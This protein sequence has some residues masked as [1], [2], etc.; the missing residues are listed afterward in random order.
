METTYEKIE[1][2]IADY[3]IEGHQIV[4]RFRIPGSDDTVESKA[5]IRRIDSTKSK[6]IKT[7]KSSAI[8]EARGF[9]FRLMRQVL[10]TG[11]VGRIGHSAVSSAMSASTS[12][13]SGWTSEEKEAAI[14]AAFEN[15][16][17]EFAFDPES[18][19]WKRA[20]EPS[21]FKAHLLRHPITDKY[22]RDLLTR[23]MVQM[24][25]ADGDLSAAEKEALQNQMGIS[26]MEIDELE[27]VAHP[28]LVVEFEK[29]SA[30]SKATMY[31]LLY[32]IALTDAQLTATE[33]EQ[34]DRFARMMELEGEQ[35]QHLQTMARENILTQAIRAGR[36]LDE[37]R[38]L[39]EQIDA[40]REEVD[41]TWV[42]D[43]RRNI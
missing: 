42:S 32:A 8:R 1:P 5:P 41:R 36:S 3:Q 25:A 20:G 27:L 14:L 35:L 10:G 7:V 43:R 9:A 17:D 30:P 22:E 15:V 11:T 31:L 28:V 18:G 19:Q 40:P 29:L 24:A 16:S 13:S 2:L 4:C 12:G 39:G 23:M 34:L 6:I 38:L 37:L 21:E 26:A 33:K